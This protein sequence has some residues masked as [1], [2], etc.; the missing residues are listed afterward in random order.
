LGGGGREGVESFCQKVFDVLESTTVKPFAQFIVAREALRFEE[1]VGMPF[2]DA[3][4]TRMVPR[5]SRGLDNLRI[6]GYM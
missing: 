6:E 2:Y 3:C 5:F 4:A 1:H